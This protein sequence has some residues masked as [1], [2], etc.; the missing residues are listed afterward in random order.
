M[1]P[2]TL[3]I[4]GTGLRPRDHITPE[5]LAAVRDSEQVLCLMT[6]DALSFLQ[7]Q[8]TSAP[9]DCTQFYRPGQHLAETYAAIVD[10]VLGFVRNGKD[11]CFALYG[12]PGV[13][14][15]PSHQALR[16]ARAEG[17]EARMLPGISAED[18]LFA[19]LGIDPAGGGCQSFWSTD[20]LLNAHAIDPTASLIVWSIG[21]IGGLAFT[22]HCDPGA[23]DLF[24]KKLLPVYGP[25]HE[26]VTYE[27]GTRDHQPCIGCCPLER[28]TAEPINGSTTLYVPPA[29]S[30]SAYLPLYERFG[31]PA[32]AVTELFTPRPPLAP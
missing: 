27:A 31:F 6:D 15:Y 7:T 4:V 8:A 20:L 9:V 23:L 12:H 24:V 26:V 25:H 22:G 16:Q 28:L 1:K 21:V 13:F 19:D 11:T 30:P 32:N 14:V 17:Y 5:S 3:T 10:C 18:C 2:G 29:L